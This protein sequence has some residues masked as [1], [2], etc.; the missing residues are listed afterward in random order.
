MKNLTDDQLQLTKNI[1]YSHL[2]ELKEVKTMN[3]FQIQIKEV[4][5][6][7]NSQQEDIRNKQYT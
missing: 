2:T 7:L 1:L 4:L 5:A 6:V 3:G